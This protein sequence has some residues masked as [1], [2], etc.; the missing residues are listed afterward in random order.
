EKYDDMLLPACVE[1]VQYP[2][3][4]ASLDGL[5]DNGEPVEL[6]S[7]SATVWEDVCA[8]KANSKAYQLYY[9]Q[10]QHQL[11]VTGA[12]QGWLVFYF[13]GQIQEFP[14]LRDEAMI[15]EILAEA[16]KF[17]QQVVDKK[18]PDKDPERD[19]YIPQGEEVNRW[20]AAA[21]EYRL[22]DAEIQELKQRLSELQ[23]R[24]KPH[25]DTMKSLM[26]EYF[27]AD[28]CGVMVTRYKAAGRVDYKKL[29]ADKASGVKPEDVDQYREKSSERCRVTVTG[30]VKPRYIVDE[31]V[32]APL[33][34]LP[35][36][37]ETFYW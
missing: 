32:L 26:G 6:K 11:L 12:K 15:Q 18:E 13:E 24:Q 4:R 23:E 5:R 29:L 14:I 33:D 31:D 9:P 1:S 16:K 30:S 27:H 20:I 2:L 3:M 28:Y 21:E 8:E 35:E 34:D 25:L 17:W 19:L 36:E 7:P 37:V 10:V 22:Y